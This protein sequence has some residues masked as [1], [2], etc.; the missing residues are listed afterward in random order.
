MFQAITEWLTRV[1]GRPP[2]APAQAPLPTRPDVRRC[3]QCEKVQVIHITRASGGQ[4]ESESH[5][6]EDC[7]LR[8]LTRPEP[9][10]LRPPSDPGEPDREVPVEVNQVII[11][12]IH[13]QQ[14]IVFREVRSNRLVSFVLG[15][16]EVTAIDRFLKRNSNP[17]PLTH[18]AWLGTIGAL[19]AKVQSACVHDRQDHTYYAELR[20]SRGA[21]VVRVDVRPSDALLVTLKADAPIYFAERLL[22]SDSV[23]GDDPT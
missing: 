16:F 13:E 21:E 14:V 10:P 18:D 5:L 22:T 15:I 3:E 9:G 7:A 2:A 17:R 6:C 19:G 1:L 11:S 8:I 12:E 23:E 20:L 4:L